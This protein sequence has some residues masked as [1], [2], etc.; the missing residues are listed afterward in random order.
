MKKLKSLTKINCKIFGPTLKHV[1]PIF[2]A[3]LLLPGFAKAEYTYTVKVKTGWKG[4]NADI[5]ILLIGSKGAIE[6]YVL[7]D[8]PNVD[9]FEP[10]QINTFTLYSQIDIGIITDI[11]IKPRGG[12]LSVDNWKMEW[13]KVENPLY[14]G[15]ITTFSHTPIF[16]NGPETITKLRAQQFKKSPI[17]KEG[18]DKI[19]IDERKIYSYILFSAR[20]SQNSS[21]KVSIK[22]SESFTETTSSNVTTK[23][24]WAIEVSTSFGD[25][26][27]IPETDVKASY[28]GEVSD[29]FDKAKERLQ[30]KETLLEKE[31]V[32]IGEKCSATFYRIPQQKV[33]VFGT[34]ENG[35]NE[36]IRY[37]KSEGTVL[38]KDKMDKYVFRA[39]DDKA[40]GDCTNCPTFKELWIESGR[41]LSTMPDGPTL[42]SRALLD[43]SDPCY[44]APVS[45]PIVQQE[46]STTTLPI[47]NTPPTPSTNTQQTVSIP[48]TTSTPALTPVVNS[49]VDL[50]N[51]F[52]CIQNNWYKKNYI[53][54]E[55]GKIEQ[56]EIQPNWWSS[57]WKIN[58][59]AGGWV[60]IQNKW[61]PEEFIHNQNGAIEVGPIQPNW[62]SGQW[63]IIPAHSGWVRIQNKWKPDQY[64]H[65]QNGKIEV[66]PIEN[67]WASALWKLE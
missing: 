4:T 43:S 20:E 30:Q 67:N 3:F 53:H 32:F 27:V 54:N 37:E 50:I 40:N 1:L 66:G 9:D 55:N 18:S 11:R 15:K 13:I 65:N 19:A 34:F 64:I 42:A 61:K 57:Q 58:P 25:G 52:V 47:P 7:M 45:N 29:S 56:G 48:T 17:V 28:A 26:I 41:S 39:V 21:E 22:D 31:D 46:T 14:P 5:T 23:N 44:I 35:F 36:D 38:L 6:D 2:V 60:T 24:A 59:V 16:N 49:D 8:N 63:K 12:G 33:I 10:N 62:W 51:D